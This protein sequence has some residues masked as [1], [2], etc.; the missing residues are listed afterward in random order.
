MSQTTHPKILKIKGTKDWMSRGFYETNFPEFLAQDCKVRDYLNKKLKQALVH[1]IE[2]ERSQTVLKIIIQTARPAL[3]IGRGGKAV[4]ELKAKLEALVG[5]VKKDKKRP[6]PEIKIE[7]LEIKNPWTSAQLASQWVAGQI[8]KMV[9]YRRVIKMALSKVKGQKEVKGVKI[10]V[11]GR[12]NGVTIS[13]TEWLKDGRLP[14]QTIRAIIEYGF[15]EANCSYGVIG[16][17]V[18]MYKGDQF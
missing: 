4:E 9:P 5:S 12:L 15:T 7:I 14:R 3:V 10:S 2:I 18:W 11:A 1:S 17:K 8:E 6:G 13:R 16:I